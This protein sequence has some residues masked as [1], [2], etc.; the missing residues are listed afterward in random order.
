MRRTTTVVLLA[1]LL[2]I[3]GCSSGG[4]PEKTTVTVTATPTPSVSPVVLNEAEAKAQ[5]TAAVAE[6]APGWADWNIDPGGWQNDP[7][8]PQEC[9]A[10]AD[11]AEPSDPSAGNRAYMDAVL[12]GLRLADDPRARS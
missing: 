1:C 12:D 11:L 9:L 8:T 2:A 6:A 5:C 7:K 4:T 10:L 3:A